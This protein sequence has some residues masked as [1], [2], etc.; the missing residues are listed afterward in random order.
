MSNSGDLSGEGGAGLREHL[1][2]SVFCGGGRRGE[3]GV[4]GDCAESER[5]EGDSKRAAERVMWRV[6]HP[7]VLRQNGTKG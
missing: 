7:F 1:A 2:E 6:E 5:G 4:R 3:L